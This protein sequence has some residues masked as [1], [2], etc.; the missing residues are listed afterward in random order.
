MPRGRARVSVYRRCCARNPLFA[1][2]TGFSRSDPDLVG[3]IRRRASDDLAGRLLR[4]RE[5]PLRCGD[6]APLPLLDGGTYP[7]QVLLQDEFVERHRHEHRVVRIKEYPVPLCHFGYEQLR[8][9]VAYA[10]SASCV[11]RCFW[12]SRI[13]C[14]SMRPKASPASASAKVSF[15]AIMISRSL[16]EV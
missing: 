4:D 7:P 1:L 11:K 5:L 2:G 3:N 16:P 12:I 9:H 14:F 10:M 6:G 15:R 13:R 8:V